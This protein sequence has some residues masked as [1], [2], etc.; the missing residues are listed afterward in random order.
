MDESRDTRFAEFGWVETGILASLGLGLPMTLSDLM[1]TKGLPSL[2]EMVPLLLFVALL[3]CAATWR[4]R[5]RH[6]AVWPL[7]LSLPTVFL[8]IVTGLG[9][10]LMGLAMLLAGSMGS[11]IGGK[12]H[13]VRDKGNSRDN[14][15]I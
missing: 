4:P 9:V 6:W 7:V 10:L 3:S 13:N 5:P 2:L 8:G 1:A 14:K 15:P 11:F 12:L